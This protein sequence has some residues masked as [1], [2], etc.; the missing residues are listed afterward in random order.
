VRLEQRIDSQRQARVLYRFMD[1][2]SDG[3]R[4]VLELVALDGLTL[5]QAAQ[6]LGIAAVSAR[7][8]LHRA[9]R[10]LRDQLPTAGCPGQPQH[11]VYHL[12]VQASVA[13]TIAA[14]R[15]F[16]GGST[17][18]VSEATSTASHGPVPHSWRVG[19]LSTRHRPIG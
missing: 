8:R 1:L 11:K 4:A 10:L 9:R 16:V 14:V 18:G 2:L 15:P 13:S 17:R 19:D 3:E 7:V 6:T 12:W 5:A